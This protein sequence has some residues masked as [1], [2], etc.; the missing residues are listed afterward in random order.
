VRKII[1]SDQLGADS[2]QNHDQA[3]ILSDSSSVSLL[4]GF[5]FSMIS[6][7]EILLIV[8]EIHQYDVVLMELRDGTVFGIAKARDSAPTY[9]RTAKAARTADERRTL[10]ESVTEPQTKGHV[11][12]VT[13][14]TMLNGL[15]GMRTRHVWLE[16]RTEPRC[17]MAFLNLKELGAFLRRHEI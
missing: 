17:E 12:T 16:K 10:L 1:T 8:S 3:T 5:G 15:K 6:E 9:F 13:L 7:A 11:D 4:D 14:E 2:Q